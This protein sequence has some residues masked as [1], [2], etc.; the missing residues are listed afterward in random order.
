MLL[1]L[2]LLRNTLAA[3]LLG[4]LFPSIIYWG[5]STC[6]SERRWQ[7]IEVFQPEKILFHLVL[8]ASTWQ[9][10]LIAFPCTMCAQSNVKLNTTF[11]RTRCVRTRH[12]LLH[13]FLSQSRRQSCQHLELIY[14]IHFLAMIKVL[15]DLSPK[16]SFNLSIPRNNSLSL[17]ELSLRYFT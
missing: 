6:P 15:E 3:H 10:Y 17:P 14:S 2:P 12:C 13:W 11:H 4:T 16:D 7:S 9:L 8:S 5:L 1:L